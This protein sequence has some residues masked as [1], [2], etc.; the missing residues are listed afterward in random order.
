LIRFRR[1]RR[2]SL[3]GLLVVVTL[4]AS[5]SA[6]EADGVRVRAEALFGEGRQLTEVQGD[7]ATGCSKF[8]ES[9]RLFPSIAASIKVGACRRREGRYADAWNALQ[10]ARELNL[11][12]QAMY[13]RDVEL[14]IRAELAKIPT[15]VIQ[16]TPTPAGLV[17]T[18]DGRQLST[19]QLGQPIP[20]D[21]GLRHIRTEALGYRSSEIPARVDS[22]GKHVITIELRPVESEKPPR[23]VSPT[24]AAPAGPRPTSSTESRNNGSPARSGSGQRTA[25]WV[26]GGIG[27]AGLGA[28]AILGIQTLRLVSESNPHCDFPDGGC[29]DTG[30][31]LRQEAGRTQTAAIVAGSLGAIALTSGIWL[32]ATAPGG[33]S[34][35]A[36]AARIRVFPSGV[37]G[38]LT[39]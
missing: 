11:K 16:V 9:L 20:V 3:L 7:W 28:A 6:Q 37:S 8:D 30:Y 25:G 26:L 1:P 4:S 31:D 2:A 22:P 33:E 13:R 23:E 18:L 14:E 38:E 29:N 35:Q 24:T 39:W 12:D 17:L 5:L 32:Y 34:Q 10:S 21:L 19:E 15:L 27:T 36:L